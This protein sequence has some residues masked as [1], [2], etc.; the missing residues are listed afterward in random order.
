LRRHSVA[1]PQRRRPAIGSAGSWQNRVLHR[2]EQRRP[3]RR[4]LAAADLRA[5]WTAHEL[6]HV[7]ALGTL[8]R[9]DETTVVVVAGLVSIGHDPEVPVGIETQVV[10]IRERAQ[11]LAIRCAAEK[12]G[13]TRKRCGVVR[14]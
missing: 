13:V 4:E 7:T 12:G 8:G 1:A 10:G 6:A 5:D 14:R 9:N 3:I 2:Q 11:L